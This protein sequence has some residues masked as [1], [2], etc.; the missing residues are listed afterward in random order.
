M[1]KVSVDVTASF[2]VCQSYD[3]NRAAAV[4]HS[5]ARPLGHDAAAHHYCPIW[6]LRYEVYVRL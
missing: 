1:G 4:T 6:A 3:G 5:P 2:C